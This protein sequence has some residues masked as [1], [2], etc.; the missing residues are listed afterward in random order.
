V[1]VTYT[2]AAPGFLAV[3][4][5]AAGTDQFGT[6]YA[7]GF[8][9]AW[10]GVLAPIGQSDPFTSAATPIPASGFTPVLTRAVQPGSYTFEGIMRL[11][12][13]T[14]SAAGNIGFTAPASS[15][16]V[17]YTFWSLQALTSFGSAPAN[18]IGTQVNVLGAQSVAGNEVNAWF[19]GVI[20]FTAAGNFV[21]GCQADGTHNF[22]AQPGCMFRVRPGA[23][24]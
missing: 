16:S 8:R 3:F 18:A 21:V 2:A 1:R 20:T 10:D 12:Q 9:V 22:T 6:S 17:W 5:A 11:K 7:A 14:A 19:K 23:G 24:T 4:A 15:F 13:G